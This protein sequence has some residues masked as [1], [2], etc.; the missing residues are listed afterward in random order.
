MSETF[1][2]VTKETADAD[3]YIGA[4]A[5][6]RSDKDADNETAANDY[7]AEKK[8]T[9][10]WHNHTVVSGDEFTADKPEADEPTDP[11]T[12]D[13]NPDVATD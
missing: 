1:Y 13:V 9:A 6:T 3:D 4:V 10:P 12:D 7:L 5:F 2:V 11:A 8:L